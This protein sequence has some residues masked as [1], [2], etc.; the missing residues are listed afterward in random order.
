MKK[1]RSVTFFPSVDVVWIRHLSEYEPSEISSLW[2]TNA[3]KALNKSECTRTCNYLTKL[4]RK[5][6]TQDEEESLGICSRGL[7]Y[8]T[9]EGFK[10]RRM[11]KQNARV[12]VLMFQQQQKQFGVGTGGSSNLDPDAS[13]EATANILAAIYQKHSIPCQE[14]A[15]EIGVYDAQIALDLQDEGLFDQVSDEESSSSLS[16]MAPTPGSSYHQQSRYH[17]G[18]HLLPNPHGSD[19]G[20][21]SYTS[22]VP[23]AA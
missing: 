1:A 13:K 23:V 14:A 22:G 16:K 15:N 2:T 20:C 3:E 17:Q 4:G 18:S 7:E 5:Y 9:L 12:A 19:S 10:Q 6:L 8:R 11:R 21:R